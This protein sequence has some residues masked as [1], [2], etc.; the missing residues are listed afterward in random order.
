MKRLLIGAWLCAAGCLP[1]ADNPENCVLTSG[2]CG[3]GMACDPVTSVCAPASEPPAPPRYMNQGVGPALSMPPAGAGGD[4]QRARRDPY[5]LVAGG[6]RHLFFAAS[7]TGA[8]TARWTLGVATVEEGKDLT[9]PSYAQVLEPE[10]EPEHRAWDSGQLTGP[11]VLHGAR[12]PGG[13]YAMYYAATGGAG[14]AAHVGQIG[15][16]ESDDGVHFRR[17]PEPVLAP[18]AD[19]A[20]PGGQGLSDPEPLIVGGYVFLYYTGLTCDGEGCRFQI[21]RSVSTDGVNFRP[22][23]VAL[24]GRTLLAAEAGGV[25]APSVR[26][27]RGRFLMAYTAV[28]RSP[29]P[30]LQGAWRAAS[31]GSV[32]LAVSEDGLRFTAAGRGELLIP[33][34]EIFGNRDGTTGAA[35]LEDAAAIYF[36]GYLTQAPSYSLLFTALQPL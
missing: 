14:L 20:A 12:A 21:L 33:Q 17:R 7:P 23:E 1:V 18:P 31:E 27:V 4:W 35:L 13:G 16:A 32:A 25:A 5:P 9:A 34:H 24:S 26:I 10:P 29:Q 2:I 22:G 36:T 15:L 19:P 8:A 30:D 28:R 3:P 6:R 11:A